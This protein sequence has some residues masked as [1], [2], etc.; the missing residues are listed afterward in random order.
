MAI[1]PRLSFPKIFDSCLRKSHRADN[2]WLLDLIVRVHFVKMDPPES[3]GA[4]YV[5]IDG[6]RVRIQRW[7]DA[8]WTQFKTLFERNVE[9][10]W[11]D[12]LYLVARQMPTALRREMV[13]AR[14]PQARTP[15]IRC[16]LNVCPA[17]TH[18]AGHVSIRA[19]RPADSAAPFRSYIKRTPGR[20][21]GSLV[22][23]DVFPEINEPDVG[24]TAAH[25]MGHILGLEHANNSHPGCRKGDEPIC[26]GTPG[27]PEHARIMGGGSR[28]TA[29]EG[30]PWTKRARI[31]TGHTGWQATT[32]DPRLPS[33]DALM[34][35]A[36]RPA[37][38]A[39]R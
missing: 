20:D 8:E 12:R 38:G 5:R 1:T 26:Y 6:R 13:Y 36:T 18:E 23:D 14:G 29:A 37:A 39:R 9:R 30:L 4:V 10:L 15:F 35:Q 22:Y 7:N 16:C 21:H 27:S 24:L 11:N 25:E 2:S 31:H 28:V 33:L 32:T 19:Y 17:K 3:K 34:E